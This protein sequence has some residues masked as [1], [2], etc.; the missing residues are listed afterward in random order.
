MEGALPA[1]KPGAVWAQTS[2]VGIEGS[3]RLAELAARHDVGFVDAPVLGTRAPAEQGTLTVLA[4]GPS[5]LREAVAPVFD[6]I[7]AKTVW[8]ERPTGSP[9]RSTRPDA[10]T[11]SASMSINWYLKEDDPLLTTSTTLMR[12]PRPGPGWR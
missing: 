4:S 3:A 6:A 8:V 2:T 7:G 9:M 11:V 12:R 10:S 1:V 5:T